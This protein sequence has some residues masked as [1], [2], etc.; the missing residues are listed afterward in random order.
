MNFIKFHRPLLLIL[1]TYSCAFLFWLVFYFNLPQLIGFP[2]TTLETIFANYD[3]PNYMVIAKCGYNRD[4]IRLNF[5]LPGPLEYYPAHLPGFPLVIRF[6]SFFLPTTKAMLVGSLAGSTLLTLAFYY[7]LQGFISEKRAFWLTVLL[8]FLPARL[9]LMRQIGAPESWFLASILF[10]LICFRQ[11]NYQFSALFAALAQLF[12]SPGILLFATYVIYFFID[13]I[14]NKKVSFGYLN[15]LLV[16]LTVLAIFWVYQLQMGDFWAY[17]HSGDNI[18]LTAFP[19]PVFIS[20]RSWIQT[21]W[22]ED[23]VYIFLIAFYGIYRLFKRY[24]FTPVF[25]FPAL[26]TLATVFVAHRDISR[27]I[28]PVYP[29]L[30]LAFSRFLTRRSFKIIFILIIP[31]IILFAIN[32]AI[33]NVAPIADWTPYLRLP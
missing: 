6:F 22:L 20:N 23:I 4:C 11:K 21:V 24:R 27:Y 26:Y 17:F 1:I 8:N 28:S 16:P 12:K 31:A 5:S 9:F 29:F 14:K 10:S 32:Y 18:H 15:Y 3:G 25:I 30:L 2:K 13:L 33:G 19:Y 7:F